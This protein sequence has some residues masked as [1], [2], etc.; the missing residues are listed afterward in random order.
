MDLSPESVIISHWRKSGFC[1][2]IDAL[3]NVQDTAWCFARIARKDEYPLSKGDL[4]L[5]MEYA[6]DRNAREW[7][8][9]LVLQTGNR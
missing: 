7:C 9:K 4:A 2:S 5:L 1:A 6:T 8:R 3:T